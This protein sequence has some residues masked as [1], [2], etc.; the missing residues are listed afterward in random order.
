VVTEQ[1]RPSFLREQ[2][3]RLSLRWYV[4]RYALIA[5]AF[6]TVSLAATAWLVQFGYSWVRWPLFVAWFVLAAPGIVAQLQLLVDVLSYGMTGRM[7]FFPL[8]IEIVDS[9]EIE[10]RFR[11]L[12]Y[13][14][15]RTTELVIRVVNA[16]G[17]TS[18]LSPLAIWS[19]VVLLRTPVMVERAR[20]SR[21]MREGVS[22]RAEMREATTLTRRF[23]AA[24]VQEFAERHLAVPAGV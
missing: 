14:V 5:L 19:A 15:Q 9:G 2:L 17:D 21:A 24:T 12:P 20:H 13:R 16:I 11:G 10:R 18:P 22:L 8:M 23:E 6:W 1:I 7:N 4:I 3:R